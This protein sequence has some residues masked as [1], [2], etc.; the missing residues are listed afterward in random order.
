MGLVSGEDTWRKLPLKKHDKVDG[1]FCVSPKV[2]LTF[3]TWM[4]GGSCSVSWGDA[5]ATAALIFCAENK[6]SNRLGQSEHKTHRVREDFVSCVGSQNHQLPGSADI[7]FADHVLQGCSI[8]QLKI[9]ILKLQNAREL[10]A[11]LC[12]LPHKCGCDEDM[13]LG[14]DGWLVS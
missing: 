12:M 13:P 1:K 10:Y 11:K 9:A 3:S 6:M 14:L 7:E 2:R 8:E 5:T 4:W